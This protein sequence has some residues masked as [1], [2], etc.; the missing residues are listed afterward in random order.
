MTTPERIES[1]IQ[2]QITFHRSQA[3]ACNQHA[4]MIAGQQ[5]EAVA[6]MQKLPIMAEGLEQAYPHFDK[7]LQALAEAGAGE[8][9]LREVA[10]CKG[11]LQQLA[12]SARAQSQ[13]AAG[14]AKTCES[15]VGS[16]KQQAIE[17]EAH[18]RGLL[19]QGE[20]ATELASRTAETVEVET[21]KGETK[22]AAKKKTT[23]KAAKKR[24]KGT[25][26]RASK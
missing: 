16:M 11:M 26:S 3:A 21:P 4:E 10:T 15:L 18:A 19:K 20:T 1:Q 9:I 24:T 22:K 7:R 17:H 2:E 8:A 6:A 23:K 5:R 14:T 13:Q 12:A 25:R